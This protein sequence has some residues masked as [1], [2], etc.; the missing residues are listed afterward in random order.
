MNTIKLAAIMA[1][2]LC[3]AALGSTHTLT[4]NGAGN[5]ITCTTHSKTDADLATLFSGGGHDTLAAG[6]TVTLTPNGA[7]T[8][9]TG[10][11]SITVGVSSGTWLTLDGAGCT[12]VS[13][14][15]TGSSNAVLKV[16]GASGV[17]I[18]NC[19]LQNTHASDFTASTLRIAASAGAGCFGVV[20]Q[21]C[22]FVNPVY[23]PTGNSQAIITVQQNTTNNRPVYCALYRCTGVMTPVT[24]NVGSVLN[25]DDDNQALVC[26]PRG[27]IY[28]VDCNFQNALNTGTLGTP[29]AGNGDG[30]NDLVG[31][32]ASIDAY[33]YGG[34]FRNATAS[35][36]TSFGGT[37]S[38]AR[39]WIYGADISGD[40]YYQTGGGGGVLGSSMGYV[41][42]AVAQHVE[43]C[44]I[45]DC[46]NGIVLLN[47]AEAG[48][49]GSVGTPQVDIARGNYVQRSLARC[50]TT[51]AG[52]N[53]SA[54]ISIQDRMA[55]IENNVVKDWNINDASFGSHTAAIGTVG[56][57]ISDTSLDSRSYLIRNNV[58]TNC[59]CGIYSPAWH[60]S[61]EI[62]GN[63]IEGSPTVNQNEPWAIYCYGAANQQKCTVRCVGNV[64][65]WTPTVSAGGVFAGDAY[66]TTFAADASSAYNWWW[67]NS[68]CTAV[69][70]GFAAFATD[71]ASQT[72]G[73]EP[74]WDARYVP[75]PNSPH[76]K[77]LSAAAEILTMATTGTCNVAS[78]VMDGC[79]Y[80]SNSAQLGCPNIP[81][82]AVAAAGTATSNGFNAIH[83]THAN[84]VGLN[85]G[86]SGA[87]TDH[88]IVFLTG[89]A[90]GQ[91]R[92]VMAHTDD[93]TH[94]RISVEWPFKTATAAYAP[95]TDRFIVL[96]SSGGLRNG[97]VSSAR[98][99]GINFT[100]QRGLAQGDMLGRWSWPQANPTGAAAAASDALLTVAVFTPGSIA[101]VA[102][103]T[104][105]R[106]QPA[107]RG[108]YPGHMDALSTIRDR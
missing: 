41:G 21:D 50:V 59:H 68:N 95:A 39:V 97:N 82:D 54:G 96:P 43:N 81:T 15:T 10:G 72:A 20:V 9:P 71:T 36:I 52:A 5:S 107:A 85:A 31:I 19:V 25:V 34:V 17:L 35:V 3:H 61:L 37:P 93:G 46:V 57:S 14:S 47:M 98:L 38:S 58:L 74:L 24:T 77:A 18:K 73:N 28:V 8:W 2:A 11:W 86:T 108:W 49:G 13:A 44:R 33:I 84:M 12:L 100:D 16:S 83:S 104:D 63:V 103:R 27:R 75:L 29:R 62:I 70:S 30:G 6:D 40:K 91:F 78:G 48:S 42:C 7:V 69:M 106:Q 79:G 87:L 23:D 32:R 76:Y 66:T 4:I 22:S 60:Q 56:N 53:A 55:I 80:Y 99:L 101:D 1:L 65:H 45:T 88:T 105:L 26:S 90:A 64:T 102:P 67:G 89:E 94:A 51:G 92:H